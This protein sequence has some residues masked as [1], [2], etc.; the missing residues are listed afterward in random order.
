MQ[1]EKI[2]EK[3]Y[4]APKEKSFG[5]NYPNLLVDWDYGNNQV[6]PYE[7]YPYANLIVNW[8]C[9]KCQNTWRAYVYS[10]TKKVLNAHFV[11]VDLL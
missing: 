3:L 2:S 4:K 1:K 6:S 10:R 8:K 7:I 5:V 11:L 9:N